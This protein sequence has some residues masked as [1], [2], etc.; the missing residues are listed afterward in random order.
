MCDVCE[1][2]QLLDDCAL[3]TENSVVVVVPGIC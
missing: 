1:V 2:Q 3:K